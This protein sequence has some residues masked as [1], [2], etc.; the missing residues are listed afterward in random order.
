M[1]SM[2]LCR[3]SSAVPWASTSRG[4]TL[5][6]KQTFRPTDSTHLR[7]RLQVR[8]VEDVDAEFG[9]V[10]VGNGIIRVVMENFDRAGKSIE[11][12]FEIGMAEFLVIGNRRCHPGP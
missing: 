8:E 11:N 4:A 10:F 1:H 6:I 3:T 12:L 7:D 5:P 2:A 9:E